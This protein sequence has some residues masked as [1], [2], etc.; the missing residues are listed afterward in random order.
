MT[1]VRRSKLGVQQ[2][3]RAMN[4]AETEL[5]QRRPAHTQDITWYAQMATHLTQNHP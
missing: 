2:A 3:P 4:D 5:W 1:S